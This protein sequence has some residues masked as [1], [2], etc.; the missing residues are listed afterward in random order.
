MSSIKSV[1]SFTFGLAMAALT[2]NAACSPSTESNGSSASNDSAWTTS[3]KL[4]ATQVTPEINTLLGTTLPTGT[5]LFAD[6]AGLDEDLRAAWRSQ[7]DVNASA[8][9][10]QAALSDHPEVA[11]ATAAVAARARQGIGA[12]HYLSTA[13]GG[14][15]LII[16]AEPSASAVPSVIPQGGAAYSVPANLQSA[17]N[18]ALS[19][20]TNNT[21]LFTGTINGCVGCAGASTQAVP[22]SAGSG[23]FALQFA[24]RFGTQAVR[25]V[26][27]GANM[28]FQSAN[29]A[30]DS[31]MTGFSRLM[32]TS[33][34]ATG[35][36][37]ARAVCNLAKAPVP[38]GVTAFQAVAEAAP[39]AAGVYATDAIAGLVLGTTPSQ[40]QVLSGQLA[41]GSQAV[42]VFVPQ[43]NFVGDAA[44][45]LA[46]PTAAV[47]LA[48]GGVSLAAR[49]IFAVVGD[50]AAQ[51]GSIQLGR[52][53]GAFATQ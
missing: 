46:A 35:G 44:R 21:A 19:R 49:G 22:A 15:D 18:N 42:P 3:V 9:F 34:V 16:W 23:M 27:G 1:K 4:T 41:T 40:T 37:A 25:G 47:V 31:A 39:L 36:D 10:V 30:A 6:V 52:L 20:A 48:F 29:A 12:V 53:A 45:I 11:I 17:V 8:G 28:L 38:Q 43:A 26:V 2:L 32:T 24:G 14:A 33:N 5:L 50:G 51:Q 13:N 7:G